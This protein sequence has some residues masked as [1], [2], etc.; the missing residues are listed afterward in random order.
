MWE[1]DSR[2]ELA[3]RDVVA[4]AMDAEMKRLSTWCLYLD[5]AHL[6]R[7]KIEHEFP[8]IRETLARLGI[9]IHRD[10][11]PVVPAQ[12]YSCGGVNTDLQART[13]ITGLF[14]A[15]EVANTGV[16]GGNRL[17]SNSLL[18]AVVFAHSAAEAATAS[19]EEPIPFEGE[20]AA[21]PC[22]TE[23]DAVTIRKNLQGVMTENVG[24]V[25][26]NAGLSEAAARVGKLLGEYD[27]KTGAPFGQYAAETHNL[28]VLGQAVVDAAMRR[29]ENVGL[30]YNSDLI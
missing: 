9:L 15:G 25:R 4:R 7:E 3:P 17:A 8:T 12:H 13:S 24:I 26:T 21:P 1:Y 22:V 6:D 20:L 19:I 27:Q 29:H 28:L 18:E 11:I 16:H 5:L 14:A 30:H 23:G 2:L 10:W